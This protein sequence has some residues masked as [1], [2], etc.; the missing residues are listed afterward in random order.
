MA[1]RIGAVEKGS[2]SE[3]KVK[4]LENLSSAQ[5]AQKIAEHFSS[6][7]SEYKPIN[8]HNLPSY[9]PA[10]PPP[11]IEEYDVYKKIIRLKKTKTTLPVDI[12]A[13]LR[14]ECAPFLAAP[15]SDIYN[16]SL[17][18]GQYPCK[19]KF[20]WV[21]PAPKVSEPDTMS[22]LRKIACTSDYSKIF[23]GFLKDWILEDISD[24][25]DIGQFGGQ[26]GIGTEHMIV[27]FIDRILKLLDTH[28]DKSA[29]IASCLDWSSAFDRQDPTIAIQKFIQLGVRASL[30]P[31]LISYLSDR[32]MQVKFNGEVSRILTLIGGGPQGTLLGG[33]EYLVQSD[34]NTATVEP[35]DR[36]KYID[37]LS[38]LQL[39]LLSGLL[40]E[41]DI[42]QHVT[43]DV[44]TDMK[45]LPP[46]NYNMQ[47]HLDDI[48]TWTDTNLMKLNEAKC[49]YLVFTRSKE[50]FATR[51]SLND[52][53]MERTPFVKILGVWISED[54]SWDKNC[55]EICKKAYKR[56]GMIT[57]LKYLGV[58]R[59][60]LLDIYK[61]F[62]RSVIEYCSVAFHS[63]LTQEQS[64]K[65]EK[66]QKTCLKVILDEE[67][68]DYKNALKIS[69]FETLSDQR[70]KRCLDFSLKCIKH[71]RNRRIFP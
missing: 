39:V 36:Y 31:L 40:V 12:P 45:Y 69:N 2:H 5:S 48:A 62:I 25:L 14:K 9:L 38:V 70:L 55:K 34:D 35:D 41:Y 10:Q 13:K 51:L 24:R 32:K 1:K 33:L 43:A 59:E 26:P 64:N 37:D 46:E 19:W 3:I 68:E 42:R 27:C 57:K 8:I 52:I 58:N 56:I 60:D 63:S 18:I 66:V 50:K 67:Y 6:I 47:G 29:V 53:V 30:I 7:S 20:E 23:E 22:D 44:G 28:Q 16:H 65:L 11:L 21:T 49:N 71:S 4:C 17:S 61:L 54:L 15:L